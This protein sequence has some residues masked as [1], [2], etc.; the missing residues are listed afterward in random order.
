ML[1]RHAKGKATTRT[2]SNR[3]ALDARLANLSQANG[4]TFRS[5]HLGTMPFCAQVS[6]IANSHTMIGLHGADLANHF[7]QPSDA[8]L[9]EL[10][11]MD[12]SEFARGSTYHYAG[13][14][15][16]MNQVASSGRRG[17][18][19]QIARV[20]GCPGNWMYDASCV[21]TIDPEGMASL[22]QRWWHPP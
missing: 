6:E 7:W 10:Y 20:S 21:I 16:Y 13:S 8:T 19:A 11:P 9:F 12:E 18:A 22:I 1:H 17:V 14:T 2:I 15:A 4:L 3:E 5:V